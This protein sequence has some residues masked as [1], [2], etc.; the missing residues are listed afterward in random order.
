MPRDLLGAGELFSRC[1]EG[2]LLVWGPRAVSVSSVAI[3]LAS[4]DT[5]IMAA[6]SRCR[7]ELL[8][9]LDRPGNMDRVESGFREKVVNQESNVL[10]AL[11]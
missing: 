1:R 11:A 8:F 9:S 4:A 6:G 10:L 2:P 7:D 5:R 3:L